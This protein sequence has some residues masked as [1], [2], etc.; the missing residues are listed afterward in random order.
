M[1]LAIIIGDNETISIDTDILTFKAMSSFI[2]ISF[3][4]NSDKI[5]NI[6]NTFDFIALIEVYWITNQTYQNKNFVVC[7]SYSKSSRKSFQ[8]FFNNNQ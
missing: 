2:F 5:E 3:R 6:V 1:N 8:A 7:G 4:D